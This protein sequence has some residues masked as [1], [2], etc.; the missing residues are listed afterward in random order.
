M[1][2]LLPEAAPCPLQ[3]HIDPPSLSA[4]DRLQELARVLVVGVRRL[5]NQ[6]DDSGA[7]TATITPPEILS[8]SGTNG[9]EVRP[10]ASVTGP[11][12]QRCPETERWTPNT[13]AE[14]LLRTLQ[15]STVSTSA[16]TCFSSRW[17][18]QGL[19]G[20]ALGADRLPGRCWAGGG[21]LGGKDPAGCR[22]LQIV[23]ELVAGEV[24]NLVPL[25][26]GP[27]GDEPVAIRS[28]DE[29]VLGPVVEDRRVEP[30][31]LEKNVPVG[32][33]SGARAAQVGHA[34]FVT[35]V[36]RPFGLDGGKG[37]GVA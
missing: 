34:I 7:A 6:R 37:G 32:P 28:P 3:T 5:R 12:R 17:S 10:E 14:D 8:D 11:T 26:A 18:A 4:A 2:P 21:L 25:L 35:A 1:R 15:P 22:G 27:T 33:W 9:L 29:C 23:D 16:C 13:G 19:R 31:G 20:L 30:G 36:R 24:K